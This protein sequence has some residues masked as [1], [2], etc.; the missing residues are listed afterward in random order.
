MPALL[1]NIWRE[2]TF[3]KKNKDCFNIWW[4]CHWLFNQPDIDWLTD[5]ETALNINAFPFVEMIE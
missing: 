3:G 4:N 1:V 5:Y 2:T